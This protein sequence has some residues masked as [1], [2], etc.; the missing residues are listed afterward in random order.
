MAHRIWFERKVMP[1]LR[2]YIPS[3]VEML[4]PSCPDNVHAGIETARAAIAARVRYDDLLFDLAPD[5][6]AVCRTGIGC[7]AI[8]FEAAMR[9]GVAI[10]NVPDGP[11]V[12]TAEHAVALMLATAKRVIQSGNRL[13]NARGNY[14]TSHRAFELDGKTLGLVGFGRIARRVATIGT[15]FGMNILAYDPYIADDAFPPPVVRAPTLDELLARSDVVSVHVPM[16]PG[17]ARMF[18]EDAFAGMRQGAVFVN[19]ARGAL[20]DQEALLDAL[21]SGH[22]FGAGLDVTDPEPLDPGHPLLHRPNVTVTPHIAAATNEARVRMFKFA[23]EQALMVIEGRRPP[24]LVNPDA[25]DRVLA[26]LEQEG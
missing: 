23:V 9:R 26:R 24:H 16:T 8:D 11:T 14:Y 6:V 21:D 25:W 12:S 3:S 17:N 4:G 2:P 10:C 18:D 20:V 15:G 1:G 19:A 7:D 22:L 13:R 5:L